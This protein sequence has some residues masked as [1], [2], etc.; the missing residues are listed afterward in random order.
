MKNMRRIIITMYFLLG[1]LLLQAQ[2]PV[3]S[4]FWG[5]RL[6]LNPA[7]AGSERGIN[8]SAA[9]R[10][11]WPKITSE[12]AAY[13]FSVSAFE[14]NIGGGWGLSA[15]QHVEGEG[16][17]KTS[18]YSFTY[19][20]RLYGPRKRGDLAFGVRTGYLQRSI[21]F[22]KLIFSDQLDPVNGVIFSTQA[23]LPPSDVIHL[24]NANA[25]LDFRYFLTK[26]RR[27][28]INLGLSCNNITRPRFSLMYLDSRL[29]ARYTAYGTLVIPGN[30]SGRFPFMIK[31]MVMVSRQGTLDKADLSITMLGI[32]TS[33]DHIFGGVLYRSAEVYTL[34][35]RDA[36]FI[37]TG[38]YWRTNEA[39]HS[40]SY[41]YEYNISRLAI[42]T[43]GSHEISYNMDLEGF[44][45]F[46][47]LSTMGRKR[48]KHCPDFKAVGGLKAL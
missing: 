3:Y 41:G 20:Y 30:P 19:A 16:F 33:S 38:F 4:H 39:V 6:Y 43:G 8:V 27:S 1:S 46:R 2:D 32:E 12:F 21:D 42:N 13:G 36:L 26:S 22:N 28:Y 5:D 18:E 10:Y 17:Q 25:G 45:L 31:P 24:F 9:A 15:M 34:P 37:H 7:M 14:P 23:E 44:M 47:K 29:P 35:R 40:F 48:V 11:Q